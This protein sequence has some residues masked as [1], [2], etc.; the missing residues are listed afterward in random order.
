MGVLIFAP[1]VHFGQSISP[2]SWGWLL[3]IG[4][5]HTGIAWV[6]IYSAYP[7][8]STPVIGMLSFIYPIVAAVIDW[9]IYDHPLGLSRDGGSGC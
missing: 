3:G 9:A 1:F 2:P 4:I 5:I 6:I 7:Q 8:L